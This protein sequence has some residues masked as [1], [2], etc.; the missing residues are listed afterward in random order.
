MTN[1][2]L[3]AETNHQTALSDTDRFYLVR[4][5]GTTPESAYTTYYDI[6]AN[7]TGNLGALSDWMPITHNLERAADELFA[8]TPNGDFTA[9]YPKGTRI[10]VTQDATTKYYVVRTSTYTGTY[11]TI[12][13]IKNSDYEVAATAITNPYLSY[14]EMPTGFP[15]QFAF[16][17]TL[18]STA[19]AFTTTTKVTKYSIAGPLMHITFDLTITA[20]GTATGEIG[21]TIPGGLTTGDV[22]TGVGRENATTGYLLQA[23]ISSGA[24]TVRVNSYNG[25]SI[26]GTGYRIYINI[27][28]LW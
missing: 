1:T 23:F 15:R 10:K 21:F 12:S 4:N 28:I 17:S 26:I 9:Y 6:N 25:A 8:T 27:D 16:A 22:A 5:M 14:A 13:V 11:T 18:T 2:K 24:S 20:A 3:S 7:I 19:G